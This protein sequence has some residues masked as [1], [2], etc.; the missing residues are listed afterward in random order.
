MSIHAFLLSYLVDGRFILFGHPF[1]LT[2][3]GY[4]VAVLITCVVLNWIY[5]KRLFVREVPPPI[6][7]F[8]LWFLLDAIAASSELMHGVCNVQLIGYTLGAG[9]TC[10]ILLRHLNLSWDKWWDTITATLVVFSMAV[11]LLTN[12]PVLGFSASMF[13][14]FVSSIPMW[15]S[16]TRGSD[17]PAS[18]WVVC[19]I[20]SAF[21]FLDGAM[22]T[23]MI[24]SGM[25]MAMQMTTVI[26]ILVYARK[27]TALASKS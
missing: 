2:L 20:G 17:E 6:S 25:F 11:W 18:A 13:A 4:G 26:L 16:I 8:A 5:L 1:S 15:I 10:I 9:L 19:F 22:L 27:R 23:K 14:M 7:V 21:N 24:A 12:N 3:S